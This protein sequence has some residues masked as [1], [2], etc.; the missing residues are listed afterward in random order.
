MQLRIPL[1]CWRLM[2]SWISR[3]TIQRGLRELDSGAT[4]AVGS[5]RV[6]RPGAGRPPTVVK[7][8]SLYEDL[9]AL[10]ACIQNAGYEIDSSQPPLDGYKRVHVFDPFGN[11]IELMEPRS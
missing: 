7:D 3:S 6:R 8:P 1:W 11:R 2:L 5:D 9:D 4:L 10:I